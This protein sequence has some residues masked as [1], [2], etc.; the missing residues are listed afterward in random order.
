M[1][2]LVISGV[3]AIKVFDIIYPYT[4]GPVNSTLSISIYAYKNAFQMYQMGYAMAT[5]LVAMVVSFLLFGIP[6]IRFNRYDKERK[7]LSQ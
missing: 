6:F 5:S 2:I 4:G 3:D 7:G 1:V